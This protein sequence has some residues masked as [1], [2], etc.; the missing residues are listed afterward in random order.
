MAQG[1]AGEVS[2]PVLPARVDDP[3]VVDLDAALDKP[4]TVQSGTPDV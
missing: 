2:A 4:T 1:S 3:P